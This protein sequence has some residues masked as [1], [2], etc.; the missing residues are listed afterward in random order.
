MAPCKPQRPRCTARP[1]IIATVG[2]D[3]P[4][5][6]NVDLVRLDAAHGSLRELAERRARYDC[7]VILDLP[8][9]TT[10]ERTSLLT[11]SEFCLFAS[12][13]GI[14]WVGLRGVS[15]STEVMR[16]RDALE[17]SIRVASCV[18]RPH[19]IGDNELEAIAA[20]SDAMVLP[21][22]CLHSELGFDRALENFER[23]LVVAAKGQR[24]LLLRGGLLSTMQDSVMPEIEQLE[25][26]TAFAEAGCAGFILTDET[27][28]CEHAQ[29][30]VETLQLVLGPLAVAPPREY[31]VA[32]VVDDG[33]L[34][35]HEL[36]RNS[37]GS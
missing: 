12:S 32:R 3:T 35:P 7:P 27:A 26:L 22:D 17:P 9:P 29:L 36:Y 33:G 11:T 34:F 14:E 31:G 6:R 24:P 18:D 19:V 4:L 20:S 2:S 21:F 13:E 37:Q 1:S 28:C 5:L 25:I 10:R 30:C 15:G 16:A 23:V 8:G